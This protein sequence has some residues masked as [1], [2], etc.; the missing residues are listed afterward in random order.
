MNDFSENRSL[1]FDSSAGPSIPGPCLSL[2]PPSYLS[3]GQSAPSRRRYIR[4]GGPSTGTAPENRTGAPPATPPPEN[5]PRVRSARRPVFASGHGSC[6]PF[7]CKSCSRPITTCATDTKSHIHG[8]DGASNPWR[9]FDKGFQS[10]RPCA[11]FG[12]PSA[13]RDLS[14]GVCL[15][16]LT[17]RRSFG[18]N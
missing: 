3:A 18:L 9:I 17:S 12:F 16:Y 5:K 13:A 2:A 7:R 4:K 15:L 11:G 14:T 6:P 10:V 8:Y 1:G